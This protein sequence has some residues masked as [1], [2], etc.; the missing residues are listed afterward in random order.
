MPAI[1]LSININASSEKVWSVIS[2]IEGS[3]DTI[4]GIKKVEI[5]ERGN[6]FTGL[7]WR[8][9][10][11]LFGKEATEVMVIS[12]SKENEFYHVKAAS[13]GSLYF[14]GFYLSESEGKTTL[15]TEFSAEI[16]S[17]LARFVN[18]LF[19]WMFKKATRAAFQQDLE[20]IKKAVE[21]GT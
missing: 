3:V 6:P 13:H 12:D 7:K 1:S 19:G 21:Q 9:T 10:R 16:Q 5:L 2:N 20:D 4:S 18:F 15:T 17:L 14:T 11:E 8:E